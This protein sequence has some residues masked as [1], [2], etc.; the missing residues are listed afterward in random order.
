MI[1]WINQIECSSDLELRMMNFS[2][3]SFINSYTSRTQ[4]LSP[5]LESDE[6]VEIDLN[7]GNRSRFSTNT[8]VLENMTQRNNNFSNLKTKVLISLIP[9]SLI[10]VTTTV[11][12]KY[13][14]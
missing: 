14:T 11:L 3:E 4:T 1:F 6:F 10:I 7:E 8:S 2:K 5:I 13:L 9:I 12:I